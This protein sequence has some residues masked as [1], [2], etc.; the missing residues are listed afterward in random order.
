MIILREQGSR[1][2]GGF[3]VFKSL[4]T[5]FHRYRLKGACV[6]HN[7]LKE[8]DWTSAGVPKYYVITYQN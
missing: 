7:R 6:L 2:S 3:A 4:D 5:P 8:F 1:W